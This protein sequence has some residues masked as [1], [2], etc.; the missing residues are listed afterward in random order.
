FAS[1]FVIRDFTPAERVITQ[2]IILWSYARELI[3]P[4]LR[5]G[6]YF[7]DLKAARSLLDPTAAI[8]L[9]AWIALV[10]LAIRWRKRE[11]GMSVAIL[12]FIVGHSL[13]AGPFSLELAF[14]HRN[15]LPAAGPL[16]AAAYYLLALQPPR[17]AWA[18]GGTI[19]AAFTVITLLNAGTWG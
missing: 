6:L 9:I 1:A 2:P 7:D 5:I 16:F 10:A 13:E 8:A 15:Y 17:L 18:L 11:P 19:T 14:L 3:A 12:W 4:D